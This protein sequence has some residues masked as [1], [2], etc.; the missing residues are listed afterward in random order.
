MKR[1]ISM[2]QSDSKRERER[3]GENAPDGIVD[4]FLNEGVLDA[5]LSALVRSGVAVADRRPREV[6][7]SAATRAAYKS[8][9][10]RPS[11]VSKSASPHCDESSSAD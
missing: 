10:R 6:Y 1:M 11:D 5:G 7:A 8:R 2:T 3:E 9:K 4:R